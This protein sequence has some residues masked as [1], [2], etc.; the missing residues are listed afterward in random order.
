MISVLF[1]LNQI[2]NHHY[3]PSPDGNGNPFAP[4]FGGKDCIGQRESAS[5]NKI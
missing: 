2:L 1:V 5:E 4:L 3:S